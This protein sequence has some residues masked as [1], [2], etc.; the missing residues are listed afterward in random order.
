MAKHTTIALYW[1][2]RTLEPQV[3]LGVCEFTPRKGWRFIPEA[4][5]LAQGHRPSRKH[6]NTW[7]E[8]LPAWTGGLNGTVSHYERW[9]GEPVRHD[10]RIEA[11][12]VRRT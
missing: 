3:R 2:H 7:E 8:C 11:P 9:W 10:L 4:H 12:R 5:F 1:D 6:W